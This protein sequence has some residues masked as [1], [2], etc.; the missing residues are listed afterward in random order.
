MARAEAERLAHPLLL[1]QQIDDQV[2]VVG[3]AGDP[4]E[5][6]IERCQRIG[7]LTQRDGPLG[8]APA[9]ADRRRP[10]FGQRE[11]V[12]EQRRVFV[13]PIDVRG[14]ER[15]ADGPVKHFALV[16]DEAVVTDLLRQRVREA[17][18]DRR[19]DRGPLDESCHVER[20]ER[21]R[22][23]DACLLYTSDAADE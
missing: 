13:H 23:V 18:A 22:Q 15:A 2:T 20:S 5:H 17:I 14:R 4:L 12:G 10:V 6:P 16:P 19:R 11:M 3:Q 21:R 9:E 1:Q 8:G 7:E